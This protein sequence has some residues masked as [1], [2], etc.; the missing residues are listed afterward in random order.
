[1]FSELLLHWNTYANKRQMPWK[2]IQDPYKI[3]LSEI[4][5][6]QTRV[7]QGT[8]YYIKIINA[9]PTVFELSKAEEQTFFAFWQGLGYYSRARNILHT[10]KIIV[11]TYQGVFPATFEEIKQ[12]K[13]IGDYT[14][15]A[16][17]SFAY[18]LPH[19][20]VDGNVV[21]VLSR[22][23][24]LY[25]NYFTH[26]GKKYFQQLAQEML[27]KNR[28]AAYNQAIMDLGATICKPKNPLCNVCPFIEQCVAYNNQLIDLLPIKKQKIISKQRFFHF[29]HVT[30]AT[31]IY[32]VQRTQQD[33][34]QQMFSLPLFES[35]SEISPSNP[36]FTSLS[37]DVYIK[38]QLTH[39]TIHGFFY[40][41]NASRLPLAFKKTC[42]KIP[43][44][45]LQ[46]YAFP[47]MI[48]S[49]F[50]KKHYL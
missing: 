44:N 29:L 42:I 3:W 13:G 24:G 37:Y 15:A 46:Q 41:I 38:Q 48:I 1:M 50:H 19:A 22:F 45:E 39:Q 4:I 31:H 33:I 32:I 30:T 11:S 6:Q 36:L 16:I 9:Y 27:D 7:E 14:A 17:A 25:E 18:N 10:A 47:K 20:V 28:P 12:L 43:I 2:G 5:L 49:F 26:A 21:R 35:D 8:S 34:W 23:F 40:T